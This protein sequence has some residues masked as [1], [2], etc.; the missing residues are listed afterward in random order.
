MGKKLKLSLEGEALEGEALE[1][2][3]RSF[4]NLLARVLNE[5][6]RKDVEE[7]TISIKFEILQDMRFRDTEEEEEKAEYI[8]PTFR[9]KMTSCMRIKDESSGITGGEG[10]EL[11]W[12]PELGSWVMQEVDDQQEKLF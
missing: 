5:M 9:H 8:Q 11:R 2:F 4:D 12:D 1:P 6:E 7:A 10:M 3:K